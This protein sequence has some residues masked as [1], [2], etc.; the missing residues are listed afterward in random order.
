[1]R[2]I[3][4]L[5]T[6]PTLVLAL[7]ACGGKTAATEQTA[8][9]GKA[10]PAAATSTAAAPAAAAPATPAGWVDADLSATIAK[11][12]LI[13]KAPVG[14]TIAKGYFNANI[15]S[16]KLTFFINDITT[17]DA[18]FAPGLEK[19]IQEKTEFK[20]KKFVLKEPDG[21]VAQLGDKFLPCRYITVGGHKYMFSVE[22]PNAISSEADA[23]QLYELAGQ[24]RAK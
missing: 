19:Q 21:F 12:P 3:H 9:A 20:F 11:L 13:V 7:A 16:K 8:D 2:T 24:T 4:L 6:A 23:R 10:A 5:L 15:V 14:Y 17:E 1:M 18:N 22:F